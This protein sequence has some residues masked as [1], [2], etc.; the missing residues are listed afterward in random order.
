MLDISEICAALTAVRAGAPLVHNITN[1]VVQNDTAS[2]IA[3]IGATQATVHNTEEA[4]DLAMISGAVV[5]NLGT[6][7]ARWT[8]CAHAA[9][10]T[11]TEMGKPWVLDPVAVGLLPYRTAL[12]GDFLAKRPSVIK[13]NASEIMA[14][15]GTGA[16]PHGADSRH[17][18]D[19]AVDAAAQL[20]RDSG[21][22]I[23]VSGAVDI[24]TDGGTTTR[25]AN[26][27]PMMA[28]MIGTGCMLG[29]VV[30]AL[31][32]GG[33]AI[34]PATVAGM[35]ALAVAGEIAAET[36]TGPGT[37]RPLLLDAL[38][39]LDGETLADRLHLS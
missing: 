39:R 22:V 1:N 35:G 32:A 29:A 8:E 28:Q 9:V 20:A 15:A 36:A 10:D 14:L 11:A 13:G 12:A 38:N 17:L 24:V 5:V 4:R 30:G 16:K 7:D 26:G 2:A 19:Q 25:I 31:L 34:L 27:D 37:L 6:P 3:A 21:A 33:G 18:P 23:A